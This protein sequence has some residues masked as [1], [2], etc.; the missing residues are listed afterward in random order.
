MPLPAGTRYLISVAAI[1][2]VDT[3]VHDRGMICGARVLSYEYGSLTNR[4]AIAEEQLQSLLIALV[5][6][7]LEA[8]R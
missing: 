7:S 3:V 5:S 2:N 8:M 4:R 1:N 6:R